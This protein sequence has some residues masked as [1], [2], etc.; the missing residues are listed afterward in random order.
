MFDQDRPFQVSLMFT[1][2]VRAYPSGATLEGSLLALPTNIRLVYK[3]L[4]E[5]NTIAFRYNL[6]LLMFRVL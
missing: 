5:I 4:P 6:I 3:G 2:G 1:G